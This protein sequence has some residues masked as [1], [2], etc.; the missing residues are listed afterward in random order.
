[1]RRLAAVVCLVGLAGCAT[2][3]GDDVQ[4]ATQGPTADEVYMARFAGDYGRLPTF[5]ESS[6]HRAGL[7]Q[8]VSAYLAAHP[9]IGTS[10]RASQFTFHRRIAVGMSREEVRLLVGPPLGSTDD[11]SRMAAAARQFWPAIAPRATE[12]WTYP[13]QWQLYFQ[14][15]RLVDL[16][17]TGKPPL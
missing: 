3:A 17:V 14:G 2:G 16:T 11:A 15:D 5:E 9:E 10:E 6:A 7:E 4:R 13:G 1:M 12:M 8:R